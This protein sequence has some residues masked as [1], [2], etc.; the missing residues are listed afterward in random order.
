LLLAG[1]QVAS[2]VALFVVSLAGFKLVAGSLFWFV[3]FITK[4]K[5]R[6]KKKEY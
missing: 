6:R 4:K 2:L 1:L 5:K 3:G